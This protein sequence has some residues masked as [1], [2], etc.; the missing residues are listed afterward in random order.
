MQE[1]ILPPAYQ[2]KLEAVRI[3]FLEPTQAA[4]LTKAQV[5]ALNGLAGVI[6]KERVGLI[7]VLKHVDLS[8]LNMNPFTG[9]IPIMQ[10][11]IDTLS[12]QSE[13]ALTSSANQDGENTRSN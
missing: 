4:A 3:A 7:E 12:R 8:H 10:P 1:L 2:Q 9:V 6:G 13:K 5:I 11:M